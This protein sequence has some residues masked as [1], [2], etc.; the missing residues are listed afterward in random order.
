M[1]HLKPKLTFDAMQI[2][3]SVHNKWTVVAYIQIH[4]VV[5]Q[6]MWGE[7]SPFPSLPFPSLPFPISI[8]S[9]YK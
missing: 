2:I 3:Q 9:P 4:N 8:P 5:R 6:R 7:V 1:C